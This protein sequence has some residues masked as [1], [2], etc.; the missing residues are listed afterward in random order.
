MNNGS[1]QRNG[2]IIKSSPSI[3]RSDFD[4]K[5]K[6]SLVI[7]RV[8]NCMHRQ[9]ESES[10]LKRGPFFSQGEWTLQLKI[11]YEYKNG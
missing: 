9:T 1:A 11:I 5:I 10:H 6:L 2:S 7:E 3:D 8:E 4:Q